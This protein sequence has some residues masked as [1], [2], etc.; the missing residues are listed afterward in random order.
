MAMYLLTSYALTLFDGKVA[1]RAVAPYA[2]IPSRGGCLSCLMT[3]N[4]REKAAWNRPH[5]G[6]IC[7]IRFG[8]IA[9]IVVISSFCRNF[10]TAVTR[11]G[12]SGNTKNTDIMQDKRLLTIQ[13]ISCV[14]QCSLTVALPIISACGI[15]TAI[16]PSSV[17][18]NHTSGFSAW[19]F[20]DLTDEMPSILAQWEKEKV[21]FD[22][23]YT[24]YV[25]QAQIPHILDIMQRVARPGALRIIDPVMGDGGKMYPGF[26]EDFPMQMKHLCQGADV[27]LPNLTEAALLLGEEYRT[28]YDQTYIEDLLRR[29]HAL[30][31]RNVVL[32]GV[33]LSEG[34]LG[35]ACYDGTT[36]EYYF[37][38]HLRV[39]MHGT[40]DCYAS[41]F[42]GALMR[43]HSLIEAASIAADFVVETIRQT[44]PDP[45]H[46]YGVKFEKALPYLIGRM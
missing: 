6:A 39:A 45:S 3:G 32:T 29:L 1:T 34:K 2:G 33:S 8:F 24:G 37:T 17:L 14:G 7:S 16:L 5:R 13:D 44:M 12:R 15:E 42:C 40:G 9:I 28:G 30:G 43:G 27:I 35:V 4:G 31:A 21:D 22:A 26:G 11:C 25:S 41:A 20:R 46:W 10:A 23:F 19:T 38:E 36:T 18:S